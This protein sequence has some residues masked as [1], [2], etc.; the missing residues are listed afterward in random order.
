[1]DLFP[2]PAF[3]TL[4]LL[5]RH[6]VLNSDNISQPNFFQYLVID[7]TGC[8]CHFLPQPPI[9]LPWGHRPACERVPPVGSEN[10]WEFPGQVAPVFHPISKIHP[11]N[12]LADP[13][14]APARGHGGKN[15]SGCASTSPGW[16]KQLNLGGKRML[17]LVLNRFLGLYNWFSDQSLCHHHC[18]E[19]EWRTCFYRLIF[20]MFIEPGTVVSGNK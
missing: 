14:S 5:L 4:S 18:T 9:I 17:W 16:R 19:K 13:N 11:Q 20:L 7:L 15:S 6:Q 1:M 10:S 2:H 3:K 8:T 12:I